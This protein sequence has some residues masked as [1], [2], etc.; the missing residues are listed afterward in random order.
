[1]LFRSSLI[2]LFFSV[3]VVLLGGASLLSQTPSKCESGKFTTC[4]NDNA[5]GHYAEVIFR[6]GTAN[7]N[8]WAYSKIPGEDCEVLGYNLDARAACIMIGAP[9]PSGGTKK[10]DDPDATDGWIWDDT[11]SN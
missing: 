5:N 2:R 1:M 4:H 7:A 3:S 6:G 9:L 8:H 11:Y 10:F